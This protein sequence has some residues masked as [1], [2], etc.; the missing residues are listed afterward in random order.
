MSALAPVEAQLAAYNARDVDAFLACYATEVVAEDGPG[1]VLMSGREEMRAAYA[2][3]FRT[4]RR[5][6]RR[7]CH[8][9]RSA[10]T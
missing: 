6:T 8:A 5:S 4:S 1:T 3:S 7:S 2:R 9:S 10:I